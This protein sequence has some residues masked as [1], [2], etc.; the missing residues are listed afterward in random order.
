MKLKEEEISDLAYLGRRLDKVL[1]YLIESKSDLKDSFLKYVDIYFI[2]IINGIKNQEEED[3]FFEEMD[4][5]VDELEELYSQ[6]F[7]NKIK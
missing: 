7:E 4:S 6:T 3:Y 5:I 2:P 1:L